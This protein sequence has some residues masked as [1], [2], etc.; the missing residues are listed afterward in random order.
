MK[1]I[2]FVLLLFNSLLA[3]AQ[4]IAADQ[5]IVRQGVLVKDRWL[6][7]L[8]QD[9]AFQGKVKSVPTSEAVRQFVVG[10]LANVP[11]PFRRNDSLIY[12]SNGTEIN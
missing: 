12:V 8:Q 7:T 3:S 1:R 10:R 11:M 6:D 9:T 4:K 5:V 2:L